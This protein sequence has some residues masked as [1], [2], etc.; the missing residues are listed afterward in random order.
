MIVIF[1]G[2]PDRISRSSCCACRARRPPSSLPPFGSR[3][4]ELVSG[5]PRNNVILSARMHGTKYFVSYSGPK[6]AS[7]APR[8]Y[9]IGARELGL[10]RPLAVLVNV[11]RGTVLVGIN[12]SGTLRMQLLKVIEILVYRWVIRFRGLKYSIYLFSPETALHE[13]TPLHLAPT[14][15][16]P[17]HPPPHPM[18][19]FHH[20]QTHVGDPHS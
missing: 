3:P 2:D 8:P 6:L 1:L 19:W 7:R 9:M 11:S 5:G 14:P 15:H 18:G 4:P 12:P 20:P 16:P 10:M 17:P 13:A